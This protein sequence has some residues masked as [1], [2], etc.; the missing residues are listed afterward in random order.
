[1]ASIFPLSFL[2]YFWGPSALAPAPFFFFFFSSFLVHEAEEL[3]ADGMMSGVP[4]LSLFLRRSERLSSFLF[5]FSPFRQFLEKRGSLFLFHPFFSSEERVLSLSPFFSTSPLKE[6]RGG[7]S[8]L[9]LLGFQSKF[10]FPF[11]FFPSWMKELYEGDLF[12][13]FLGSGAW[14]S[15]FS[16]F[17]LDK[18]FDGRVGERPSPF[19]R[20]CGGNLFLFFSLFSI[21]EFI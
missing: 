10:I 7:V 16:F 21:H 4:S 5:L 18:V 20:G 6:R 14:I 3:N 19:F 1:M 17:S 11:L 15:F 8:A 9:P 12:A 2:F 13:P